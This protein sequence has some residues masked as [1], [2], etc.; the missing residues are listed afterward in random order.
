MRKI[1]MATDLSLRC[2]H[3]LQRAVALAGEFGAELEVIHVVDESLIEGITR[4]HEAAAKAAIEEQIG[5]L[6]R[7]N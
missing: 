5:A 4:Q 2:D 1:V 7:A 6:P 3:A